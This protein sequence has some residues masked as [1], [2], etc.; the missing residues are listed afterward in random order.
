MSIELCI[1]MD[2]TINGMIL[3]FCL[4]LVGGAM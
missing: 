2:E 4:G 3:L 1:H